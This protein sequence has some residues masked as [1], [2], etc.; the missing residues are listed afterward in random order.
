MIEKFRRARCGKPEVYVYRVTLSDT[1]TRPVGGDRKAPLVVGLNYVDQLRAAHVQTGPFEASEQ[2]INHD[3]TTRAKAQA[4]E[5]RFTAQN[6]AQ[7]FAIVA[8]LLCPRRQ[9]LKGQGRRQC[10]QPPST[11]SL[12]FMAT[13]RHIPTQGAGPDRG[14]FRADHRPHHHHPVTD[15]V[16]YEIPAIPPHSDFRDR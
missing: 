3:P 7:K 10:H 16:T 2:I 8:H 11:D 6:L 15:G 12:R 4:N 9:A 1:G 13:R 5:I 14:S